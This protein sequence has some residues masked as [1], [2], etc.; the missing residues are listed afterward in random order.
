MRK[1]CT[2]IWLNPEIYNN[3]SSK[4]FAVTE[5][6]KEFNFTCPVDIEISANA[7]YMLFVNGEY[8]GRGPACV[9]GDFL[10]GKIENPYFEKYSISCNGKTEIRAIVTSVPTALT[11][12]D[13]GTP[14][15]W[16]NIYSGKMLLAQSDESWSVRLLTE[17]QECLYT[18][19]TKS[20]DTFK[21]AKFVNR[22]FDMIKSPIEHLVEENIYP[23]NFEKLVVKGGEKG[24]LWLNFDKIYSAYPYIEIEA[25]D[26]CTVTLISSEEGNGG[27]FEE[28]IV[29]N[30]SVL[31]FSPRMRSIGEIKIDVCN[32]GTEPVTINNVYIRYVH[33]PV[34]REGKFTCS[35]SLL[36]KIYDVCMHTLKICRQS[37]HLDSP[38][39]QEHLACTG[40][41]YIQSMIEYLSLWDPTLAEW[42]I[43]RTS[44]MLIIQDGAIFHTTYSL[45]YADWLYEHYMH[46]KNEEIVNEK[47]I[48]LLLD[49]FE[50]YVS[51]ENG[52]LEYAPNYMFVDWVVASEERDEFLD[53]GNMMSHGKM[54]G[55]SLHHPP[56][57]LGQSVLCMF[58]Y[59]ALIKLSSLF[60]LLKKDERAAEYTKR[61]EKIKEAINTHLFDKEKNLYVGGLNT[62]NYVKEYEW[63]PEN[64]S[65][66]YYLKQANVLSVL[67]EIAPKEKRKSILEYVLKDLNIYEMQPYFYYFLLSAVYKEGMFSEYGLDLIRRYKS[68]LDKCD[69]GLSEAWENMKC[70]YSHA[71]GAAP[72][73]ILKKVLSGI[74]II[75]PGYKKIRLNPQLF[76]LDSA[77]F[78]ITT[79][80]GDIEISLK[81]GRETKITAPTEITVI[82]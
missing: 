17:R 72:A 73:Y 15:L 69:K 27:I 66:V 62:P 61:A 49:R 53:G 5:F 76:N 18:D 51:Q 26:K 43:K 10:E 3:L 19:Y 54:R 68:L 48:D 23:T 9:G 38:T 35:D 70:D 11:E 52:L 36:N 21:F 44:N 29:T 55:Y 50:T 74:E 37:I 77:D 42:D 46:T 13:F 57:A 2:H 64:T 20:E 14:G 56:K 75:E 60:T 63:L 24:T 71:W 40:D 47:A 65:V 34:Y 6:K 30:K 12:F 22:S 16:V 4:D 78:E 31:H 45:I 82:K 32:E 58:Y 80:Y 79:P 7:R 25:E 67:F 28:K 39:H 8:I 81:K 59:N 33:Y 1:N 41:Y